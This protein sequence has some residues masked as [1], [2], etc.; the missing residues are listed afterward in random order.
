[1]L[2]NIAICCVRMLRSLHVA[3]TKKAVLKTVQAADVT[4]DDGSELKIINILIM[5]SERKRKQEKKNKY[6]DC[7]E[8]GVLYTESL[9]SKNG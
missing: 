7:C 8:I 9:I 5:F 2:N 6:D 3:G 4:F 1:M